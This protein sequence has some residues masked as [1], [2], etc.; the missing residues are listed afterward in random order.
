MEVFSEMGWKGCCSL[1]IEV[2]STKVFFWVENKGSRS[3]S[4]F[5]FFKKIDSRLSSIGNVSFSRVDKQGNAMA[6]VLAVADLNRQGFYLL[7]ACLSDGTC[8]VVGVLLVVLYLCFGCCS[9][10]GLVLSLLYV[11][12]FPQL[13]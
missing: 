1:I 2:G 11:V 5:S 10:A 3:W 7:V 9:Q 13:C 8:W 6:L 4:L 12:I